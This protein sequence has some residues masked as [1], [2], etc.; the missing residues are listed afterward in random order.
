M[1][2]RLLREPHLFANELRAPLS[3]LAGWTA[4]AFDGD[5][6]PQTTPREWAIARAACEEAVAQLNVVISEACDE[7]EALKQMVEPDNGERINQLIYRAS[8]AIDHSRL[9]R[10]AVDREP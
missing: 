1:P 6:G 3:V 8:L 10:A 9:V 5:I 7:A 2:R 4:L